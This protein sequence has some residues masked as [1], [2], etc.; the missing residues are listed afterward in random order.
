MS[1]VLIFLAVFAVGIGWSLGP[2]A[3]GVFANLGIENL[4]DQSRPVGTLE[5][6]H[7]VLASQLVVPDEHDSH[8]WAIK[9]P[10]GIA[11]ISAALAGIFFATVVYL[12]KWVSADNLARVLAPLYQLS[13]HKWWFDELYDRVFVRPTHAI[14]MLIAIVLDRG[15]IDGII[16]AYAGAGRV[17]A[18]V[19]AF[20]GDR[21]LIDNTVDGFAAKT[22]DVALSLRGIQTGRVRQYVMFIVVGTIMLFAV[23]SVWYYALSG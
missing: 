5:T 18:L 14:G 17:A 22:W 11:A 12:W 13:W 15:L 23:A 8:A 3:P 9:L 7:G 1:Y 19:V 2:H 6:K 21:F 20:F 10:A 4:L 16:H